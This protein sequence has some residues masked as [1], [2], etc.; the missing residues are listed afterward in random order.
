MKT[1]TERVKVLLSLFDAGTIDP[2]E[3]M[4]LLTISWEVR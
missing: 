4:N 3:F 1:Y 2:V